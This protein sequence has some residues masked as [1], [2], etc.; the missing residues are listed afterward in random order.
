MQTL[1]IIAFGLSVLAWLA[2][3]FVGTA[4][5]WQTRIEAATPIFQK[6][7]LQSFN[8][9]HMVSVDLLAFSLLLGIVIWTDW[10][11][12][13]Q[14]WLSILGTWGIAWALTWIV[15]T[16]WIGGW[17][18]T[19]QLP[20]WLLIGLIGGICLLAGTFNSVQI[21]EDQVENPDYKVIAQD[22]FQT[23]AERKDWAKMQSFYADTLHFEDA[24]LQET[25]DKKGFLDFYDWTK[26]PFEKMSSD[27]KHFVVKNMVA[28]GN[29]VVTRG[30]IQPF[31]YEGNFI[32][33]SHN[34]SFTLWLWF[35]ENGKIIRQIDWIEYPGSVLKSVAARMPNE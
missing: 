8:A 21:D 22:Y 5:S 30:Q 6:R 33:L 27:Q 15:S 25:F 24:I 32:P 10:L 11:P 23:Y 3:T 14:I 31:Y 16:V 35:N 17:R 9:W 2:H 19:L 34:A 29:L 28:D 12:A 26:G 18:Q 13:E 1:L 4:E 20:Q 7:W